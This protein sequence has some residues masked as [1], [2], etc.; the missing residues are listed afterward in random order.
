[1]TPLAR[2]S[3][4]SRTRPKLDARDALPALAAALLAGPALAQDV[5]PAAAAA[6]PLSAPL[7]LAAR[8][9]GNGVSADDGDPD[10]NATARIVLDPA[11]G[12]ACYDIPYHRIA[13]VTSAHIHAGGKGKT[14]AELAT[15]KL[16]ADDN[17]VGCARLAGEAMAALAAN[18]GDY[19]VDVHTTELP[20]GA[21]RG[22]L[23]K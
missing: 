14:G 8:L 15:L 12:T 6:P 22:Q 19:Y 20:K 18:P 17:L 9:D 7:E 2:S 16:D 23:G 1:M 3:Q 10:G 13:P 5:P 21:I 11:K 4:A